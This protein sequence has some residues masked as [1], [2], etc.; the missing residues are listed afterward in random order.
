MRASDGEREEYAAVVREAVGDGRLTM[1]EGEERQ[2]SVYRA[3][4]RDELP[5]LVADLPGRGVLGRALDAGMGPGGAFGRGAWGRGG[6]AH[7]GPGWRHG[8]SGGWAPGGWGHGGGGHGGWGPPGAA[9]AGDEG[10]P[11]PATVK[12]WARAR[13]VR[14][15]M[16]ALILSA[17]LVTI[18]AV[19]GA[20]FFWPVIPLAILAIG[21]I[22]HAVWLRWAGTRGAWRPGAAWPRHC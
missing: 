9:E 19:T 17:V 2:V 22:K 8:G 11:D 20:H 7:G 18:W 12:R 21:L 4:F 10:A 13:F 16:F 1:E 14:H 3:K 15:V 6:W 5:P